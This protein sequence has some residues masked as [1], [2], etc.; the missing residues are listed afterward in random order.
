MPTTTDITRCY[1]VMWYF[2]ALNKR[3]NQNC[4]IVTFSLVLF[5]FFYLPFEKV[6]VILYGFTSSSSSTVILKTSRTI[7]KPLK[8]VSPNQNDWCKNE[9]RTL[10]YLLPAHHSTLQVEFSRTV[11]HR[12][13]YR[14]LRERWDYRVITVIILSRSI[15]RPVKWFIPF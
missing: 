11:H 5:F 10:Y 2:A 14:S 13:H 15:D 7:W 3:Q 6:H 9:F 4:M 8:P 1:C 12:Y